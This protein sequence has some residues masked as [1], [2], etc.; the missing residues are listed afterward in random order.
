MPERA[1]AEGRPEEDQPLEGRP[2]RERE[3]R[4][5]L[6]ADRAPE[7][8]VRGPRGYWSLDE[9]GLEEVWDL[10]E[11]REEVEDRPQEEGREC[12]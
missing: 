1:A 2:D 5:G 12:H 8:V 6:E 7:A 9:E 10:E 3:E 11:A 4:M